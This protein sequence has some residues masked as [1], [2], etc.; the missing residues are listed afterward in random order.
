MFWFKSCPKCQ[1]DLYRDT[2]SYGSYVACIQCS[3]YLTEVEEARLG[4]SGTQ[5]EHAATVSVGLE[6]MA[7]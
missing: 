3:H 7:A 2:D 5:P 4:S 6:R 1:G